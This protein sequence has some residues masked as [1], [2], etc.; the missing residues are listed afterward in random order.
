MLWSS[1]DEKEVSPQ[2]SCKLLCSLCPL[3]VMK[4]RLECGPKTL[5][6]QWKFFFFFNKM[7][8]HSAPAH[9]ASM[10]MNPEYHTQRSPYLISM[11]LHMSLRSYQT[12]KKLQF[13]CF[14]EGWIKPGCV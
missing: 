13:I 12:A 8:K 6:K 9:G 14:G 3:Y 4:M 2:F 10:L 11:I 7:L 1:C 5:P